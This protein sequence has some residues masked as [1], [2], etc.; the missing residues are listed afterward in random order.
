VDV[1]I[2]HA[3]SPLAFL[4]AAPGAGHGMTDPVDAS[5]LLDVDVHQLAGPA[6]LIAIL[7]LDRVQPAELAKPYRLSTACTV[8]SGTPSIQLISAPVSR[9]R[10]S[11]AIASTRSG[12]VLCGT[13]R[14]A[15]ERSSRPATPSD[16]N[17]ESHFDAD[18]S[19]IPAA[20]A[21]R[22]IDHLSTTTRST[23]T[24]DWPGTSERYGA[25]SSG[26][27]LEIRVLDNPTLQ[28]APDEQPS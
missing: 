24:G 13:L 17:R 12:G 20:A 2:T 26:A 22:A 7:R 5:Q 11:A 4:L 16:R 28:E 23:T 9:T 15:D 8:E 25:I 21:A 10:R 27:S 19:L 6:P 18:R 1:L 3:A 14:G